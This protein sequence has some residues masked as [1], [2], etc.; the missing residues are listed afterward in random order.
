MW[1]KVQDVWGG[2]LP[3]R[4]QEQRP[5]LPLGVGPAGIT[6]P[7]GAR[8]VQ[9][10]APTTPQTQWRTP[11]QEAQ[12][13]AFDIAQ[14]S[15][16]VPSGGSYP[17]A[18][19]GPATAGPAAAGPTGPSAEEIARQRELEEIEGIFGQTKDYLGTLEARYREELP[20]SEQRV[21]TSYEAAL[22]PIEERAATQAGL[23]SGQEE[24][25]SKEEASALAQAR[26]RYGELQQGIISRFGAG[27]SAGPAASEIL[28]RETQRTFAGVQEAAQTAM[29]DLTSESRRLSDFVGRQKEVLAKQKA[30]SI[31]EIRLKFNAGLAQIQAMKGQSEIEKAKARLG[32][33][34]A[35]QQQAFQIA[36]AD[37]AF[38]RQLE[39]FETTKQDQL[40]QQ[41]ITKTGIAPEAALTYQ[42][43]LAGGKGYTPA[44]A[45]EVMEFPT[46]G[47]GGGV[48]PFATGWQHDPASNIWYNEQTGE[49]LPYGQSPGGAGQGMGA[50]SM[51]DL[52]IPGQG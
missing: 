17:G 19:P 46:T 34:Q 30:D 22:V 49:R 27:T 25:V 14:R 26:Q 21:A 32:T 12:L 44:A 4:P 2:G 11:E 42:R 29:T 37:K 28:A 51:Y 47:F 52:N 48:S 15:G 36:Q 50:G 13:R 18:A 5:I 10:A 6:P 45:A 33:M 9:A 43:L 8:P 16:G 35:Y 23:I 39:L 3:A 38:E 40:S 41:F 24:T 7:W 31:K 20:A 1:G